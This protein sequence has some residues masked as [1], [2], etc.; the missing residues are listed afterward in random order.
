MIKM[1]KPSNEVS[2]SRH[3]PFNIGWMCVRKR[4]KG[5]KGRICTVTNRRKSKQVMKRRG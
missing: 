3:C 5:K 1:F 4:K 2:F